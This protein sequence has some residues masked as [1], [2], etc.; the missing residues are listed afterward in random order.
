MMAI[1]A[2]SFGLTACSGCQDGSL[3]RIG[4]WLR[5]DPQRPGKVG[6]LRAL[7][8]RKTAGEVAQAHR[9]AVEGPC[10]IRWSLDEAFSLAFELEI[11]VE[12]ADGDRH[13]SEEGRWRRDDDGRWMMEVE[14]NFQEG[15]ELDGERS[16]KG[17]AD[18]DGFR[19]WLG[20]ELVAKYD[21]GSQVED[22]WY[23]EMGSRF[24]TL[25]V[26]HSS[27]WAPDGEASEVDRIW[28]PGD[29]QY[30]CGPLEFDEGAD[31]WRALFDARTGLESV[32][33]RTE[34]TPP[35]ADGEAERCRSLHSTHELR[36]GGELKVYFRE[37]R[38]DGPERL[39]A[40]QAERVVNMERDRQRM[41][42]DEVLEAWI[43]D[44]IVEAVE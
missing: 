4:D 37:C 22:F 17:F 16:W 14:S 44:E 3:D 38:R 12:E 6:T 7:E 21:S 36:R 1:I 5:D 2:A 33:I 11:D 15:E 30:W 29:E 28:R 8:V 32:E 41:G 35:E 10:E 23:R 39:E 40:P 26:L 24:S 31:A 18:E 20:P 13:W 34:K 25:T 42:V 9:R 43:E 27:K 19:E